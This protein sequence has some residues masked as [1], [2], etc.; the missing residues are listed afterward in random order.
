MLP[1]LPG[2]FIATSVWAPIHTSPRALNLP[3]Q[4]ACVKG[5]SAYQHRPDLSVTLKMTAVNIM[6]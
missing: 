2:A 6:T 4:A 5:V 3:P 1:C